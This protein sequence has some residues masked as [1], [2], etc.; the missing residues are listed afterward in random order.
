CHGTIRTFSCW[1]YAGYRPRSAAPPNIAAPTPAFRQGDFSGLIDGQGRRFTLYDGLTTDSKTWMRQ[2]FPGNQ[3]PLSRQ[4]P[5]A[6]YLYGVTP[7]PT[8]GDNPLV[9]SNWFGLGFANTKQNTE[10]I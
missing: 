9:T 4:S 3:L 10:T 1:S 2:P 7:L 8:Q 5:L 6:K